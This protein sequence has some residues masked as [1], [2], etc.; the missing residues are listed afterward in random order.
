[1][2]LVESD[3][4]EVY[5]VNGREFVTKR[6]RDNVEVFERMDKEQNDSESSYGLS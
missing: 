3:D 5:D 1:M 6:H 2:P 4:G